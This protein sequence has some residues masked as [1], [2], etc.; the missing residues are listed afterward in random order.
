M[1]SPLKI[2]IRKTGQTQREISLAARIPETRL[3]AL[4]RGRGWPSSTERTALAEIL[5]VDYFADQ[6]APTAPMSARR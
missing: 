6:Q 5:G 2:A 1:L 4:V 3:S